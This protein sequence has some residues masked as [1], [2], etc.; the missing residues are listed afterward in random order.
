MTIDKDGNGAAFGLGFS[1]KSITKQIIRILNRTLKKCK[2][3]AYSIVH[4]DNEELALEYKNLLTPL[5][6][7][8]PEFICEISSI[9]AI[10]SG[11]GSVAVCF[12]EE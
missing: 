5:L 3:K 9:V 10:H 7:K 4:A 12:T 11:L 8:E 2:I 1:K 6:G